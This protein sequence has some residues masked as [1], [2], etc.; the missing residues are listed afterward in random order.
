M[1]SN[2]NVPSFSKPAG[3]YENESLSIALN[4]SGN[5]NTETYY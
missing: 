4:L 2:K 1:K 3:I 5:L